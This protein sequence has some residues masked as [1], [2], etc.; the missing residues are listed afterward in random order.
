[1]HNLFAKIFS[2]RV[3]IMSSR[4]IVKN[5]HLSRF[6]V[7]ESFCMKFCTNDFSFFFPPEKRVCNTDEFTCRKSKG[8]CIPLTWMCDGNPDCSDGSDEKECSKLIITINITHM[9]TTFRLSWQCLIIFLIHHS[10]INNIHH[11]SSLF[12][13]NTIWWWLTPRQ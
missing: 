10:I 2:K 12:T 13:D 1:M 9:Y 11:T 3:V 8:E 4:S 5:L 7:V 6:H